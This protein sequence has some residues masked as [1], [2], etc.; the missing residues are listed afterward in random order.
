MTTTAETKRAAFNKAANERYLAN[1]TKTFEEL[2]A[3]LSYEKN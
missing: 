1:T 2:S 3:Y